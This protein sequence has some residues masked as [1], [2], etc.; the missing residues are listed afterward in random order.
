MLYTRIWYFTRIYS[1][2]ICMSVEFTH[3][4]SVCHSNVLVYH[5]YVTRMY[6]YVIRI[7]LVGIPMLSVCLSYVLVC[8]PYVTRTY[9]K[10][11]HH[12]TIA[13]LQLR[14]KLTRQ[15]LFLQHDL[16]FKNAFGFF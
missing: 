12:L 10:P 16:F 9:H 6:S 15:P 3:V 1:Y 7:S 5:P 14:L 8:H 2:V 13:Y 11:D 4:L